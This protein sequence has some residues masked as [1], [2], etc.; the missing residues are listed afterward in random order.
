MDGFAARLKDHLAV[1]KRGRLGVRKDG[2]WVKNCKK[3]PHIL[4]RKLKQLN[5]LETIRREFWAHTKTQNI[6]LHRDFHHLNSS[7]AMAFNLLFPFFGLGQEEEAL[8]MAAIPPDEGSI[9]DWAFEKISDA[10]EGTAFDFYLSF[11]D[12]REVKLCESAFGGAKH[13]AARVKKLSE[14][15]TARLEGKV[16]PECLA[17]AVF[18]ENYQLLR[19]VSYVT[20][21]RKRQLV[22]V[23]PK[24]NEALTTGLNF[25][26]AALTE[27]VRNSVHVVYL[28]ELIARIGAQGLRS[29][30]ATHLELFQEKYVI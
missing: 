9:Q 28:E 13:N 27:Q 6:H 17:E 25:V 30:L 24:A 1:Y 29:G 11:A 18:F 16:N 20:P 8:F 15:Y 12:G 5:V 10:K 19:N 7:Q 14:L 26:R 3:Y 2:V 4:P 21:D 22:V 23:C